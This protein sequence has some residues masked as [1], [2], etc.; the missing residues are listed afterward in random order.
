MYI[1]AGGQMQAGKDTVSDYLK[2]QLDNYQITWKRT[3]FASNVKRI[4]METFEK[5]SFYIEKWKVDSNP[6]PD[7]DMAVRKALQFIG[8]GFRQIKSTIW[9]D[10][11]FRNPEPQIISDL[12]YINEFK[13]VY[14]HHGYCLLVVNPNKVNDDPNGSEAQIK[15]LVMWALNHRYEAEHLLEQVKS[16]PQEF[17][18]PEEVRYINMILFND[19]SI[20]SLYEKI[21]QLVV[22]EIKKFFSKEKTCLTSSK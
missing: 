19:E 15:P 17:N 16:N 21:D 12:R 4:F 14:D 8:D 11:V 2:K 20:R 5:D 1:G 7:L 3:A 6:P 13:A 10:L 22:P 18:A 9:L